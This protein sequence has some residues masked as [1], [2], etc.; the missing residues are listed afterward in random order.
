M[1]R[2]RY[3][4]SGALRIAYELRGTVHWRRPW[5]VL[6]QGMGLDRHGWGPVLSNPAM[7]CLWPELRTQVTPSVRNFIEDSTPASER[8][9]CQ[10]DLQSLRDE[11]I[12]G[13]KKKE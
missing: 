9:A 13:Q 5:L 7:A 10:V 12:L 11:T 3:A 1:S 8:L 6:I 4:R 2:T